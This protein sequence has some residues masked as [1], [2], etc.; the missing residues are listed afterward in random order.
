MGVKMGK[1]TQTK[2]YPNG[3]KL[4]WVMVLTNPFDKSVSQFNIF[5]NINISKIYL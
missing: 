4:I 2:P 5:M 1:P 3:F